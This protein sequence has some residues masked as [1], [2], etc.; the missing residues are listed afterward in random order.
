MISL[1]DWFSPQFRWEHHRTE[2]ATWFYKRKY[3]YVKIT[4]SDLFG[5]NITGNKKLENADRDI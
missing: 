3:E 1:L 2:A 4:T 5:F